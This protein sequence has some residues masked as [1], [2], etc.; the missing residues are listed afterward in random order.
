MKTTLHDAAQGAAEPLQGNVTL[1]AIPTIAPFLLP[2]LLRLL[3]HEHPGLTVMLREDPTAELLQA[4]EDGVADFAII[5]LPMPLG[6]LQAYPI[7]IEELWLI[8]AENDPM[9]RYTAPRVAQIDLQRLM[10]LSDGHCLREHSLQACQT[11]R[12]GRPRSP[13]T[14][15][16][17]SLLTLIQRVEAGLGVSLV[18][19]MA[20]KAGLLVGT[21]VIARPMA[22]PSPKREIALVARPTTPRVSLRTRLIEL[23][24]TAGDGG[25]PTGARRSRINAGK[26]ERSQT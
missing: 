9:A 2:Q 7:F 17:S 5:A 8:A 13:S 16:A 14:I 3:R 6:R 10:L 25:A 20:V 11:G 23:A 18:P 15:E 24:R 26:A 1:G 19:E 21:K 22:A 12:R 4:V